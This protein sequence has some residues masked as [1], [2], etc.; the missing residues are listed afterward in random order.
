[1]HIKYCIL[2]N[3]RFDDRIDSQEKKGGIGEFLPNRIQNFVNLS[4]L[5]SGSK[6]IKTTAFFSFIAIAT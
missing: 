4:I 1:M 6:V 2:W 5:D 3:P